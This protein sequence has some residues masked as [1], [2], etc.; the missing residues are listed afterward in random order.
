MYGNRHYIDSTQRFADA[1]RLTAKQIEALDLFDAL[2]NDPSNHLDIEFRPGDIYDSRRDGYERQG[3]A[4]N[5]CDCARVCIYATREQ[6]KF[7]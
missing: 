5:A 6:A 2:A 7:P 1:P 4:T 3:A